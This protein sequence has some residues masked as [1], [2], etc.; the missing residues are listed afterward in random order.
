MAKKKIEYQTKKK[1]DLPAMPFYVGDWLKCPEV[2][3]LA[4]DLRGLWFDLICYMWQ[5]TERGVMVKP[6]GTPY[7]DQEIIRMVGL[8]NQGNDT[9]LNT[10]L[11]NGVCFRRE[12]GAIYSR[13][14]KRM[15][16]KR[17]Q[18]QKTGILGGNP[19]LLNKENKED[20]KVNS[21]F[22]ELDG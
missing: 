11:V 8:D 9:W 18:C 1:D 4:P 14:M 7:S 5:S 3:A 21:Y 12:D 22:P 10:L 20:I 16:E 6:N 2:R 17:E 13:F 19:A 15:Q